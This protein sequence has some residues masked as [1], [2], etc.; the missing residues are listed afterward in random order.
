M[1]AVE[2]LPSERHSLPE[3]S[4]PS[5]EAGLGSGVGEL[6]R[7]ASM[8]PCCPVH[9]VV[10]LNQRHGLERIVSMTS[11]SRCHHVCQQGMPMARI[12]ASS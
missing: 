1:D 10:A 8:R 2:M 5:P 3:A 6:G 7:P 11:R 9:I 12:W 4:L